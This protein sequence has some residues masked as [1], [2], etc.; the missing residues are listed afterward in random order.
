MIPIQNVVMLLQKKTKCGNEAE[1]FRIHYNMTIE[2]I[3]IGRRLSAIEL[4]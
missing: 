3:Y 2:E 4:K 1:N